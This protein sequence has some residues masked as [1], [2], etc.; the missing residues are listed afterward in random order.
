MVINDSNAVHE[1]RS[2]KEAKQIV[3]ACDKKDFQFIFFRV[4][5][6]LVVRFANICIGFM[7]FILFGKRCFVDKDFKK[8]LIYTVGIVGDNVV[9]LPALA[10]IRRK[11]RD[12][13]ITVISNCQIWEGRGA[14]EVLAPSRFM[15]RLIIISDYPVERLGFKLVFNRHLFPDVECDLFI[16]LSP[17]GNR[18]WIGAVIKEL[19]FAYRL[20]ASY[21]VGFHIASYSRKNWFN[22]VKHYFLQNEPR[23]SC[24]ILNELGLTPIKGEDLFEKDI[25]AKESVVNKLRAQGW[26]G[27]P[28]YIINPGAKFMSKCWPA[29]RFGK[30]AGHIAASYGGLSVITGINSEREIAEEVVRASGVKVVNLAGLTSIQELVELLRLANGCIT[31]D[32]GTMHIAAMIGAPTVA[33]F[34]VRQSPTHWF[35]IGQNV[36]SLFSTLNCMFCYDDGC[37]KINCLKMI[38][39]RHVMDA[40]EKLLKVK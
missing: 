33:I 4:V 25:E 40:L 18:G 12:A 26:D 30:I 17:F 8:I 16:N 24:R 27:R 15:D 31:N 21:A 19:I 37:V 10:A 29:K 7:K 28:L 2:I 11:Y 1:V 35:P 5:I 6:W 13:H 38:E 32:T 22:G 36:I 3:T 39:T 14:S 34:S 20:G 23:R 9:M